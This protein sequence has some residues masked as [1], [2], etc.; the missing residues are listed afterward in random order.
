MVPFIFIDAGR[1]CYDTG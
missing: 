1:S